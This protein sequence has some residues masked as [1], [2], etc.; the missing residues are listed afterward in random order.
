MSKLLT[1][2][3]F[4]LASVAGTAN[5]QSAQIDSGWRG[6]ELRWD[7]T[8]RTQIQWNAFEVDGNLMICGA[9]ST[10][11]GRV[12]HDF[13][14]EALRHTQIRL[15]GST[16]LRSPTFFEPV[17]NAHYQSR[18]QGQT[19]GC[20]TLDVAVNPSDLRNV[21]I[22]VQTSRIRGLRSFRERTS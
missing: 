3:A 6:F 4:I 2:V 14:K 17:S 12:A 7:T 21:D 13:T 5:A 18:L 11:G 20:R 1:T 22:T 9:Y 19:A 16:I 8:R 10:R 15:N